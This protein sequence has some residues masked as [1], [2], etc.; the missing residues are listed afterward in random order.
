MIG[1]YFSAQSKGQEGMFF[2]APALFAL[3]LATLDVFFLVFF[4]KETLPLERRV[5]A[6]CVLVATYFSINFLKYI[7]YI[8]FIH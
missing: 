3:L 7:K 4:M 8:L 2:V 6:Y 1:A 5:G